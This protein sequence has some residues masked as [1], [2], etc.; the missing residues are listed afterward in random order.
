MNVD[1]KL[2]QLCRQRRAELSP[3][4]TGGEHKH[5]ERTNAFD[6]WVEVLDLVANRDIKQRQMSAVLDAKKT[7][8]Q[9]EIEALLVSRAARINR[10]KNGHGA[11]ALPRPQSRLKRA[12]GSGVPFSGEESTTFPIVDH[13]V[14][15]TP[16]S[17]PATPIS[18][19]PG[20]GTRKRRRG[21]EE[22]EPL[23]NC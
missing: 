9:A 16:S 17:G 15:K 19:I 23:G 12:S 5:N 20:G 4:G 22:N 6:A 3:Q 18:T 2:R 10:G 8:A 14:L 21:E 11:A 13:A 1:Q 7:E